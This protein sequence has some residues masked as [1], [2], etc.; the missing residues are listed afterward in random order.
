MLF[1]IS[2]CL[3]GPVAVWAEHDAAIPLTTKTASPKSTFYS[4]CSVQ[5]GY[6]N[7]LAERKTSHFS[8]AQTSSPQFTVRNYPLT[9]SEAFHDSGNRSR[10]RIFSDFGNFYR[11]D[12]LCSYGIALAAGGILA[13][14]RMDYRFQNWYQRQI[15]CNFTDEFSEFTRV[16][17]EGKIFI[18]IA[19]TTACVYRFRQERFGW[20]EKKWLPGEFFDRTAR[21]YAV[22]TPTLLLLQSGLGGNRPRDGSSYWKPFSGE[23]HTISGHA[24]IGA[25][26]FITAAHMVDPLW[27]KGVFYTLSIVP[28]WSRVNDSA[29]Y[30]SQSVLGWYLAYLSVR[31]VSETEGMK[32]LPKGLM[33]FPVADGKNVGLGFVY[34]R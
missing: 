5:S 2:T 14:T 34:R 23:D 1:L 4:S 30:L 18:P 17:G 13:N 8:L 16:F 7:D 31:A 20:P 19:V 28:A 25:I 22:G 11:R 29:H 26:P 27:L 21:G 3:V 10:D 33:L 6:F 24:F 32:P 12:T 15:R 9:F